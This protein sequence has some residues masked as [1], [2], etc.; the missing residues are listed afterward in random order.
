MRS[1]LQLVLATVLATGPAGCG[2]DAAAGDADSTVD[3][4]AET[5]AEA[6]ADGEPEA[7]V[8]PE[9]DAEPEA[10][11]DATTEA[12]AP[13]PGCDAVLEGENTGFLVDG[14][15]RTFFLD[16]PAD[17]ETGGPWPVVFNF[18]GLGD[19]AANMRGLLRGDVDNAVMPFILVTPEDNDAT[20]AGLMSIDWNVAT[21]AADNVEARMFD[22]ILA[23]LESRWGVDE[24]HVHAVGF[25]MGGFVVDALGTVRGERL[26][27]V[28]TYSGGYGSNPANL[29]GMLASL[30]RWPAYETANDYVQ[31]FLHGGVEDS[32]NMAVQVLHFDQ[33]AQSDADWLN[34]FGH[35]VLVCDHGGGH[36]APVAGFGADQIVRFFADHPLGTIDSPYAAGLPA[37]L[38]SYCVFQAGS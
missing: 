26:A 38:P 11:A 33:M 5:D 3:V 36:A 22:E 9:A 4:L 15:A 2:D 17:A 8:A 34:G 31:V 32:Y 10:D 16:L 14:T 29:T 35:D 6:A 13:A 27:S 1:A 37:G 24:N 30:V 7:D 23:C 20:I 28:L 25:S 19:T 18:H 21:V 12:D